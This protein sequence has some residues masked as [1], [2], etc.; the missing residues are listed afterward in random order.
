MRAVG[1]FIIV[2][3][4]AGRPDAM[5]GTFVLSDKDAQDI[6]Y[7]EAKVISAGPECY[8]GVIKEGDLVLY[9][10]NAGF[11]VI[12]GGE[13]YLVVSERDVCAVV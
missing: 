13:A 2:E 12:V 4:V 9:D 11:K 7:R 8:P 10:R 5:G 6:R 3:P 1:R